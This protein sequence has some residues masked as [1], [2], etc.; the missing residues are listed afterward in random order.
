MQNINFKKSPPTFDI[1][2]YII[3]EEQN[4]DLENFFDYYSRTQVNRYILCNIPKT[5]EEARHDFYY[6]KNTFM[7]GD[8]CYFAIAKKHNNKMIGSIGLTGFNSYH[9]RIE[10]SY[11]LSDDYWG[12]G[13]MS[14]ALKKICDY[15]FYEFKVNKIE[16]HVVPENIASRNLLTRNKFVLEGLLRGHRFHLNE[17]REVLY[18][19][20]L[21]KDFY[22]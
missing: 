20:L 10:V 4:E 16:A 21:R 1:G 5:L 22:N 8:G 9:K 3:R 14:R 11:D 13:I 19:G 15:G 7:R 2:D 6:W 12:Q 18:F 17:F